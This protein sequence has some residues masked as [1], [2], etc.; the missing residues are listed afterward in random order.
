[1]SVSIS[2]V[3]ALADALPRTVAG[4]YVDALPQND[5]GWAATG[6]VVRDRFTGVRFQAR[7]LP[8]SDPPVRLRVTA[9][10]VRVDEGFWSYLSDAEDVWQEARPTGTASAVADVTIDARGEE[11]YTVDIDV[12]DG[13]ALPSDY[14]LRAV[15]ATGRV[16]V[17]NDQV[18]LKDICG[19]IPA[20]E[21]GQET[22]QPVPVRVNG[23]FS[24][25]N[26]KGAIVVEASDVP[27]CADTIRQIPDVGEEIWSRLGPAGHCDL[28]V[29]LQMPPTGRDVQFEVT[30]ALR[31]ARVTHEK[32][33]LPL[34]DIHGTL[35]VDN[36][37]LRLDAIRGEFSQPAG[38][39]DAPPSKA[40]VSVDG[41]YLFDGQGTDLTLDLHG[42]QTNE[43]LVT[44]IPGVGEEIWRTVQPRVK[45][46]ARVVLGSRGQDALVPE[47]IALD[48]D[49][50][51]ALP[52]DFAIPLHS[53]S[54]R[55]VVDDSILF[56]E[57]LKAKI[58][59]PNG[60]RGGMPTQTTA[61][62]KG[63]VNLDTGDLNLHV[64]VPHVVLG[65]TLL[66]AVPDVGPRIWNEMR[67]IGLASMSAQFSREGERTRYF[68]DLDVQDVSVHPRLI[69]LPL[70][71]LSGH[72]LVTESRAVSSGFSGVTCGGRFSGNVV[73]HYSPEQ[74]TSYAGSLG[75]NRISLG[76]LA[77]CFNG[78]QTSVDGD[79][80]GYVDVGGIAG[81]EDSLTAQGKVSLSDGQLLTLPFFSKLLGVLRLNIPSAQKAEQNGFA[82]FELTNGKIRIRETEVT[83]DGLNVTGFGTVGLDKEL[84]LTLV[85]IGAP[86]EGGGIPILS[87]VVDLLLKPIERQLVR[88]GVSGP[89]ENPRFELKVLSK[90]TW[91]LRSLRSLLYTPFVGGGADSVDDD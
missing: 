86:E 30:A 15:S 52:A 32:L 20:E 65:E 60:W 79:L 89:L 71:G 13:A 76:Q 55:A 68:V 82:E 7:Y 44:A 88:V 6:E 69:P 48:F 61:T 58:D 2:S 9:D 43:Q 11:H 51:T 19:T 34:E 49:G 8:H 1:M 81:L 18:V 17:T 54:G 38:N 23:R 41:T 28:T 3:A 72:L 24:T 53:L 37:G 70:Q 67:P 56:I 5:G 22:A 66:A 62:A 73:A 83:G 64:E 33:P 78:A 74:A 50:G 80:S 84:D 14:P 90:I 4:L 87:S 27:I 91:P 57:N 39:V 45:M 12:Q 25:H 59:V 40:Q 42:V 16:I 47:H 46:D 29:A 77:R 36:D 26:R 75:F 21:F 10:S 85:A 63:E 31:D 35:V